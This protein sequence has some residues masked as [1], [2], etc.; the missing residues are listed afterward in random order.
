MVLIF[1]DVSF[2]SSLQT[3]R[4][5]ASS[6]R[7]RVVTVVMC[8][9][10]I[11]LLELRY[12]DD[13]IAIWKAAA[14]SLRTEDIEAI[15]ADLRDLLMQRYPLP[16]EDDTSGTF[17]GLKLLPQTN[18]QL[19]VQPLLPVTP[20][21]SNSSA[22]PGYMIFRS[23][24]PVAIKRAFVLGVLMRVDVYTVPPASK[25]AVWSSL[26]DILADVCGFPKAVISA[27]ARGWRRGGVTW[28]Q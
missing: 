21:Y 9:F 15:Q 11:A 7:S 23:Y 28:W 22:I 17:V 16:M 26:V 24:V 5:L 6:S 12:V 18:G 25:L 1:C 2:S 19:H 10:P 4:P 13:Y 14:T 27:W 3:R 20:H 8:G